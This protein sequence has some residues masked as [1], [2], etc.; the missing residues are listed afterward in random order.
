MFYKVLHLHVCRLA[1]CGL[2]NLNQSQPA[3]CAEEAT[4]AWLRET[5][6]SLFAGLPAQ[7]YPHRPR[8][9]CAPHVSALFPL[10]LWFGTVFSLCVFAVLYSRICPCPLPLV[11]LPLDA[12]FLYSDFGFWIY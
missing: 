10:R 12:S 7:F 4:T 1:V 2:S 8:V 6:C 3:S 9:P 11:L 5:V